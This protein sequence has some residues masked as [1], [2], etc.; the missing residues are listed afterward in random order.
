MDLLTKEEQAFLAKMQQQRMNHN[1]AQAKYRANN[2]DKVIEYNKEYYNNQRLLKNKINE[3][4]KQVVVPEPINIGEINKSVKVD[5]HT[6]R[7]KKQ[8]NEPEI[9]PS[10]ES[11]TQPLEYSTIDDYIKKFD[12]LNKLFNNKPL[13]QP[14]KAEIRK[15]LNDNQ[16]SNKDIIFNEMSFII[17]DIDNTVNTIR[18][19]YINDNSFKSY[20]NILAV[21]TSHFKEYNKIYMTYSKIAKSVN[22]EVQEIREQN[23]IEEYEKDKIIPVGEKEY[24]KN[25]DKLDKIEDRLIYGLYLLFPARRL[26]YRNMKITNE[27]DI[28]KLNDI[29]NF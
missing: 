3:K 27:K 24:N 11:R 16:N 15:V 10:Y 14:V 4:L 9:I 5:K 7:G 13:P 19:S 20:I 17:K 25:V 22:K 26:D 8:K 1:I 18:Q 2:K 21:L 23:E 29:N 6:R 28:T 12:I